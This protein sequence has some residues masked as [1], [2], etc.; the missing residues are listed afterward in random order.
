[1]SKTCNSIQEDRYSVLLMD[2]KLL[3]NT[4]TLRSAG[5]RFNL[6]IGIA[7]LVM[8]SWCLRASLP[9]MRA[10]SSSHPSF[11]VEIGRSKLQV[12]LSGAVPDL[13]Q[14]ALTLYVRGAA[15]AVF[16]YYGSF[17][18]D[19]AQIQILV[20]QG[21]EGVLQGTTWGNRNG[22][23]AMI[24]MRIGQHT[25]PHELQTDWT[26]THE[27]VHTALP[28]LPD[29]QHW[30][31]EGIS[32]YVEPIARVQA[33]QLSKE[34]AWEGMVSGMPHGEP[35]QFDQ[36]LDYTHTWGR[37]YWGGALFCLA[38]DLEIHKQTKNAFG[39][40]DALRAV[41]EAH[42]S[43][44]KDWPIEQVLKTADSKTG[45]TVLQDLYRSWSSKPVTIDLPQIWAQLGV[46]R[47]GDTITFNDKAPLAKT[48]DAIFSHR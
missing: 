17:P 27:M 35:E 44:D 24:R 21:R 8:L 31:E 40:Q 23:P 41:V 11:V 36:G 13:P 2:W 25:T 37:T 20:V 3:R 7:A 10:Q 15:Q 4:G 43:I 34:D 46:Q 19:S 9:R 1:M 48:R 16:H 5:F 42:G 38:A 12:V 30:L 45:T 39:L 6:M 33:G 14:E 32:T 26:L 28:S 29:A 47:N 22:F 18:V